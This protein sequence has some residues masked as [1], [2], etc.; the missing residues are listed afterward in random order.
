LRQQQKFIISRIAA[1]NFLHQNP[2][3]KKDQVFDFASMIRDHKQ[4]NGLKY[5][6][7]RDVT[8]EKESKQIYF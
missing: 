6:K 5:C 7:K 3:N 1:N 8:S 2:G 4:Q